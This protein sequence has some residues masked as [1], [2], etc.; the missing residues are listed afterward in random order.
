MTSEEIPLDVYLEG[1]FAEA[2]MHLAVSEGF[3]KYDY[4]DSIMKDILRRYSSSPMR[5]KVLSSLML[6]N[7]IHVVE[8]LDSFELENLNDLGVAIEKK[9]KESEARGRTG[10]RWAKGVCLLSEE[11]LNLLRLLRSAFLP[12]LR[13]KW[14]IKANEFDDIVECIQDPDFLWR[15]SSKAE[16]YGVENLIL[17]PLFK[18]ISIIERDLLPILD[19]I[20]DAGNKNAAIETTKVRANKLPSLGGQP[21]R[22]KD[23]L[24]AYAIL[25]DEI[26]MIP[27]PRRRKSGTPIK[28]LPFYSR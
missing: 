24:R 17:S 3:A 22:L 28:I 14:G 12:Y 2:F 8:Y 26:N 16:H 21:N 7:N 20:L 10:G 5:N 6:Y 15:E 9:P 27:Q 25:I 23:G 4:L 19:L 1:S 13:R 18:P 11:Q